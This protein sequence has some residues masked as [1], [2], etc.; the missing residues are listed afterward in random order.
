MLK[1]EGE[2]D[3]CLVQSQEKFSLLRKKEKTNSQI[4]KSFMHALNNSEDLCLY[5]H[6]FS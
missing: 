5:T 1:I 3:N 6:R 4:R 2:Q